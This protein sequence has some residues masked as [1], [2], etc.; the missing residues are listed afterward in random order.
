MTSTT[1]PFKLTSKRSKVSLKILFLSVSFSL[2]FLNLFAEGTKQVSPNSGT[3]LTALMSLPNIGSGSYFNAPLDNRVRFIIHDHVNENLYFGFDWRA[4][5]TTSSN[6]ARITN[7]YWRIKNAAGTVVAGPTLWN[8]GTGN[9][10][11]GNI[12]T[13]AKAN[14][15][16]NINGSQSAGYTPITFD[17]SENGEYYIEYY[18]SSNSGAG[19]VSGSGATDGGIISPYFDFTVARGN[20]PIDG[21][22]FSEKWGFL[23][24]SPSTFSGGSTI[25]ATPVLYTY[26][27]DKT[28]LKVE[29]QTGFMPIAFDIAV[30]NYGVSR[31]GDWGVTRRSVNSETS[32]NLTGGYKVFLAQPDINL[33]PDDGL[34]AN[35]VFGTPTITGCGN[36]LIHYSTSQVG[37]VKILLDLNG[38][39]GYQPNT[40]DRILE[41]FDVPAGANTMPWDGLNG[42]G[43]PVANNTNIDLSLTYMKGR[44]NL[45]LYDAEINKNGLKVS[46][47][48]PENIPNIRLYWD[49]SHLT[50]VGGSA[51]CNDNN[52]SNNTTGPGIDNSFVGTLSPAHAWSGNGN[53]NQ[54][55]PAPSVDVNESSSFQCDDFGNVRT[56]N[57]WGWAYVSSGVNIALNFSPCTYQVISGSVFHDVNGNALKNGSEKPVSGNSANNNS[58]NSSVAGSNIFSNLVNAATGQVVTSVQVSNSGTYTFSDV[59]SG[60]SYNIVL[61]TAGTSGSLTQATLPSGWA[62]TGT[63]NGTTANVNNKSGIINI[64]NLSGNVSNANFGIQQ[65]PVAYAKSWVADKDEDGN[66][67]KG[68]TLYR[69]GLSENEDVRLSGNDP[70]DGSLTIGSAFRIK[71]LPNASVAVLYYLDGNNVPQQITANQTIQNYDPARMFVSFLSSASNFPVIQFTY[72]SVDAAGAESPAVNYTI[73]TPAVLPAIGLE[74]SVTNTASGTVVNWQTVTE[75]NTRHFIVERSVDGVDYQAIATVAASGH[76]NAVQKYNIT[77]NDNHYQVAYYR[78]VL[79]DADNKK[80]ISNVV[81]NR[82]T[83]ISSNYINVYPNPA[84]GKV[85]VEFNVAGNF[86]MQ[87]IDVTGKVL[88]ANNVNAVNGTVHSLNLKSKGLFI[89]KVSGNQSEKTFRIISE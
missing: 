60:V 25:P 10:V 4:Y 51:A 42:L 3:T 41:A 58:G 43:T 39:Q 65:P 15:G 59:P 82:L 61:T 52:A 44:F 63:N 37:D 19:P 86:N 22:V 49:D 30:N 46:A 18:R 26:T 27:D 56:I 28:V 57:T 64:P 72:A 76:S 69:L 71:T 20:V 31:T 70:E 77:D 53:P 32:P 54:T 84:K 21:R 67:F 83:G 80:Q 40:S 79:V 35:P 87:V 9:S 38:V 45:P 5:S 47:V 17:P 73:N 75:I 62:A 33:F 24:V 29:L 85:Q 11:Q 16:P 36:Y 2:M 13:L 23:G 1:L 12:N 66:T 68:G 48:L 14:A 55:I 6:N 7:V 78:V 50:T 81:V 34:P 8:S 74:L 89:I 88:Q